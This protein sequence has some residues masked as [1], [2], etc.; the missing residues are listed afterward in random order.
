[1]TDFECKEGV[2]L[3][4]LK[5]GFFLLLY[6]EG[7]VCDW[8]VILFDSRGRCI[9][10]YI[11][12]YRGPEGREGGGLGTQKKGLML[13]CGEGRY[14]LIRLGKYVMLFSLMVEQL[15]EGGT[16]TSFLISK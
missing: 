11:S 10:I 2:E 9:D 13:L 1:M 5:E 4:Q 14:C 6:S 7:W 16:R 15:E 12:K 3:S 8:V